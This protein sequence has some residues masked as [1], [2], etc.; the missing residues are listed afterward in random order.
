MIITI[1]IIIVVVIIIV[2]EI[3]NR[4]IGKWK[5]KVGNWLYKL[6]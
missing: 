5:S 3:C 6:H 4:G 1:T 2:S